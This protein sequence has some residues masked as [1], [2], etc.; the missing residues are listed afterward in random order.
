LNTEPLAAMFLF[1]QH[2]FPSFTCAFYFFLEGLSPHPPTSPS[3]CC[4]E[5]TPPF[6]GNSLCSC[7][8][9]WAVMETSLSRGSFLL[10]VPPRISVRKAFFLFFPKIFS[11]RC[12]MVQFFSFW[13]ANPRALCTSSPPLKSILRP[14]ML[15]FSNTY[16]APVF[17]YEQAQF[18]ISGLLLPNAFHRGD[19]FFFGKLSVFLGDP[20]FAPP[21][22]KC[23]VS[24]R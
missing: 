24:V 3:R 1:L 20:F 17:F 10:K 18:L 13:D 19:P 12:Y 2:V 22:R 7:E 8:I 6:Q 23:F 4:L 11:H 14:Q 5:T 9:C 15:G 21:P 16:L